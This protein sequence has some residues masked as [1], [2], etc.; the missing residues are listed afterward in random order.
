MTKIE[1]NMRLDEIS[2]RIQQDSNPKSTAVRSDG[3]FLNCEALFLL[4]QK[5]P[6]I[7]LN[8]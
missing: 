5:N 7:S 6:K 3:A 2:I 4:E 8:I 1:V